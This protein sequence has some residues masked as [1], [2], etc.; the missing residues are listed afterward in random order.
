MSSKDPRVLELSSAEMQ[1]L[2]AAAME[3]ICDHVET[4]P[5]QPAAVAQGGRELARSLREPMPDAGSPFEELLELLFERAVPTSFNTASPGYLAY[6]P[7]GGIFHAALADLISDATNRYVGVFAAAP[8]LVQLEANVLRWFCDLVGYPESAGGILT[9]GGSLANFSAVVAARDTRLPENFLDGVLYASDQ[10][11]HSVAKAAGL[12]GFRGRNLRVV[13]SDSE[14]RIS[15]PELRARIDEDRSLGLKPFLVVGSAGTTNTGAIDPLPEL[16]DLAEREGLWFHVDAAYGGFFA[17]TARGKQALQGL[18]RADSLV[19]DPHK[20]LFL[21]YGTG[22]LL[23]RDVDALRRS[24]SLQA[25]YMPDLQGENEFPDFC[26]ISPELSRPFR[27]LRVWLPFKLHG[28]AAF[29][30]ALDEKLD[31]ARWAADQLRS[32]PSIEIVAGPQLSVLAF[33]LRA[34]RAASEE[35]NELNRDFLARINRRERVYLTATMLDGLFTLRICVLS[36][37]THRDRV[38]D[39]LDDIGVAL[40]ELRREGRLADPD[41]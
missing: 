10:T 22:A 25:D 31:L 40:D 2:V 3:R 23:V 37:R 36:F 24:H 18:G 41:D 12:A 15:L 19:L 33:R 4:L 5:G 29:E 28:A 8:G 35:L 26:E 13:P 32:V 34:P 30:E 14:F 21:P 38:A 9:S 7:G 27:G 6:I 39:C 1:R 17:M 11:H 20:G 16:A